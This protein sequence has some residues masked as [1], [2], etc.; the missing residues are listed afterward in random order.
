M[1]NKVF[2]IVGLMS[3]YLS[4]SEFQLFGLRYNSNKI[5]TNGLMAEISNIIYIHFYALFIDLSFI[6]GSYTLFVL[7]KHIAFVP[8]LSTKWTEFGATSTSRHGTILFILRGY[9]D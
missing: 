7:L 6:D 8:V 1:D 2:V 4:E 9:L 3:H 5:P